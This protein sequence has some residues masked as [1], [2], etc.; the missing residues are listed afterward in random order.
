MA[1]TLDWP[2]AIEGM[3]SPTPDELE[4]ER[5][6]WAH[7]DRI[8]E[9]DGWVKAQAQMESFD[10]WPLDDLLEEL[11][12]VRVLTPDQETVIA[13]LETAIAARQAA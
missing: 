6:Y 1:T 9:H 5:R 3:D 10:A 8:A 11:E 12:T 7:M 2:A 4:T 13:E